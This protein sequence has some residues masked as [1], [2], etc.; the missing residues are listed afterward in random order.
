VRPEVKE[1]TNPG[2]GDCAGIGR[3]RPL[4]DRLVNLEAV[5]GVFKAARRLLLLWPKLRPLLDFPEPIKEDD[6]IP[7]ARPVAAPKLEL[8]LSSLPRGG[9]QTGGWTDREKL[10][11]LAKYVAVFTD[12]GLRIWTMATD[13]LGPLPG[14]E[15]HL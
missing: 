6:D 8:S 14:A 2:D 15:H 10:E 11:A 13:P 9:W 5:R 3:E 7:A 1:V 12:P 4:F